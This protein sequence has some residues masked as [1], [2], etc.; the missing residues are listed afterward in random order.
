MSEHK[1]G[2]PAF[3][4]R[5]RGPWLV[6]LAAAVI[7]ACVTLAASQWPKRATQPEFVAHPRFT[8]RAGKVADDDDLQAT[9]PS[10]APL[11]H[12]A[13]EPPGAAPPATQRN[14]TSRSPAALQHT[15]EP[16]ASNALATGELDPHPGTAVESPGRSSEPIVVPE[17]SE[18]PE[19]SGVPEASSATGV[20]PP[21]RAASSESQ[22]APT[23]ASPREAAAPP[24]PQPQVVVE[25]GA[26]VVRVPFEGTLEHARSR[27]WAEPHAL[28]VDLPD[29]RT[30]LALGRY[31]LNQGGVTDLQ[32]N[33]RENQ[34]LVRVKA[35][36]P[37]AAYELAIADGMLVARLLHA[38]SVS[39]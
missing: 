10:A 8:E 23:D 38:P 35:S 31:P 26:T 39:P 34:L 22:P 16:G 4:E 37:I 11:P 24:V 17:V 32:L 36:V 21:A 29:G 6:M 18:V 27:V 9:A 7:G 13:A 15:G 2:A 19:A 30:T 1:Q 28:A 3:A 12:G 5:S 25:A 33:G 14:A 20:L